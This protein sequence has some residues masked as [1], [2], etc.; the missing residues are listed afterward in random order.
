MIR[1]D[2]D[3][4][5]YKLEKIIVCTQCGTCVTVCP[6]GALT[7]T[8]GVIMIDYDKCIGC[9]TC[10]T[11]CPYHAM[12]VIDGRPYKCDLCGGDPQCI[13]YCVRGVLNAS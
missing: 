12:V 8:D 13:K 7:Y 9:L 3:Y 2:Y 4:K 1:V 11:E 10:V 6:R 5:N